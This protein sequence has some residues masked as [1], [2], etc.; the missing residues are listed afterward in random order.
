MYLLN[1]LRRYKNLFNDPKDHLL[2]VEINKQRLE[3]NISFLKQVFPHHALAGV[4][5]SNAYGHGLR[6]M[7]RLPG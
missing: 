5:K 6:T 2:R 3:D 7:G 1:I 4:L